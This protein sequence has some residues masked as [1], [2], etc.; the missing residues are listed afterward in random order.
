MKI[1]IN[2]GHTNTSYKDGNVFLQ[3]KVYNDFNHKI[4]Y[5]ILKE[6]DFVPELI[7]QND[8]ENK[9]KFINGKIPDIT[10]ETLIK[11][12]D[13]IKQVH[14]SKLKFPPFN[15]ASRIKEYRKIMYEKGIKIPIIHEYY[16]RI[17]YIIKNQDKS[18]PIHADIWD[19]NLIENEEGKLFI[20]DWEYAHMGD[21]NFELAYIIES[22]EL[23]DAQETI[24]LKQYDDYNYQFINN[25]KELVNYLIILWN[26]AQPSKIFDDQKFIDKLE[27]INKER[28]NKKSNKN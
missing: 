16:K 3:Q 23:T 27:K 4:D 19:Q 6:F 5:T 7:S 21:K 11:I 24:F 22:L 8:I 20:F 15:I 17:N 9:W 18:T 2:N 10:D 28:S 1:K 26:N 25:H 12:A 14:N 13:S